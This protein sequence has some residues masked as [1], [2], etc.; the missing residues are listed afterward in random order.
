[1]ES[2]FLC[3]SLLALTGPGPRRRLSNLI[4]LKVLAGLSVWNNFDACL[5]RRVAGVNFC[6][7]R[8][9]WYVSRRIL[10]T[11]KRRAAA[12]PL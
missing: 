12:C 6:L 2:S 3:C 9:F 7:N 5:G 10:R 8:P 4:V 11:E 1:M